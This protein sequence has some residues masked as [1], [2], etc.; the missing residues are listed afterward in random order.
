VLAGE[1]IAS[2]LGARVDSIWNSWTRN[3]Q[4]PVAVV[5]L[6][7]ASL[8]LVA[9]RRVGRHRVPLPAV[10]LAFLLPLAGLGWV[11]PRLALFAV[12]LYCAA[13]A[14]GLA[15][16]IER[17]V[18]ER[19]AEP[20]S[21]AVALGLFALLASTELRSRHVYWSME[22]GAARDAVQLA[23]YLATTI[24]PGDVLLNARAPISYHLEKRGIPIR[25]TNVINERGTVTPVYY[26]G[27]PPAVPP[28]APRR[29]FLVVDHARLDLPPSRRV[30][31]DRQT[32]TS[33]LE[34]R[35]FRS[36]LP[37]EW[38]E[39]QDVNE[40]SVYLLAERTRTE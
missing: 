23:D 25:R 3:C 29:L 36:L 40:A 7:A 15:F 37:R 31:R 14:A 28:P 13:V 20:V 34:F 22:T 26:L 27:P 9:H 5:F 1:E 19:R 4:A 2:G 35:G 6:A 30:A 12:P 21:G 24:R 8:A 33:T 17:V 39:V 38:R 11:R 18:G 10:V 16:L 32:V